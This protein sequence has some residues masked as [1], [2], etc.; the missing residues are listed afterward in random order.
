VPSLVA[1]LERLLADPGTVEALRGRAR[2]RARRYSWEA[3]TDQYEELLRRAVAARGPGALPPE[4]V[5]G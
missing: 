4:L 1:Q 3:V 5:E 2:E